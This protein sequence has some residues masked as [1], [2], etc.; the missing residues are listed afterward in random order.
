MTTLA[1]DARINYRPDID[2]LRAIAVLAVVLFHIDA[3]LIQGGFAGVDIFFVI[4]GFLITGNIIKDAGSAQGFSWTEFYRRRALR[5]LPVLFVVLLATLLVGHFILLPEDLSSL[6]YSSLAAVFSAANVY[7]TYFLDTSYF[8]DD[9][10][11][12]P[13]LHLWSLGVEEQF[14]LFWPVILLALLTRFTRR[15]LLSATLLLMLASFV[16]AQV[17]IPKAPMFAYYMLPARAGE[18]MV[19]ALL[20]IWL[21]RGHAVIGNW[22][23]VLLG[24]VGAGLIVASLGWITEDMGFPGVNALPSTLGAALL[25]WAG[26]GRRVGMSRLLSLRPLVLVGLISYSLYLWHWP[27]LAFYRYVYGIVEPLAGVLLFGLMLL[28]SLASYRWVEKPCRRLHW[29]FSQVMLRLVAINAAALS[30]FCGAIL[31]SDG[32]GLYGLDAQYRADI[33]RLSPAPAAYSYPYVCQRPR[34]REAELQSKACIV[35]AEKEP[36]VLLWGDSNAAHYVGMLGAFAEASGFGFRNA[37]HSS[38]PPLLQG[39]AATQKPERLEQCLASIEVVRQH[40]GDYSTVI[41]GAAWATHARKSDSFL[42]NLEATVDE[43]VKQGKQVVIMASVPRF[44]AVNR[45]CS[46]KSLKLPMLVCSESGAEDPGVVPIN[47][48]LSALAAGR[49]NVHF[50]DPRE[51]LCPRGRCSAYL[52]GHLVYFDAGHLSMEGSWVVGRQIVREQGVPDFFSHLGNGVPALGAPSL[53]QALL[54]RGKAVFKVP[55]KR[56]SSLMSNGQ[57]HGNVQ[58]EQR[59]KGMRL[60][61]ASAAAFSAYRYSFAADELQQLQQGI[62]IR[63]QLTMTSCT[64]AMPLLRLRARQGE[65]QSQYDVMLDCA[66]AQLAKRGESGTVEADVNVADGEVKVQ[67]QYVLPG[68]LDALEVSIYPSVGKELGR[69]DAT[70]KGAVVVHDIAWAI[71][72]NKD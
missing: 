37:A 68:A 48:R 41:L 7:F 49:T 58:R 64:D 3:N 56:W 28:L 69:Y 63:L 60:A 31:W 17:L 53:E 29:S 52:D 45:K 62:P 27:V 9:S 8:A 24:L 71:E 50:F 14:Y 59:A 39:T 47:A 11:L 57:W 35:N 55:V 66:S 34:L 32:F 25:I 23:R 54:E 51:Q 44:L 21:S 72:P 40:L 12:Q 20:A 43:L 16:L 30:L 61:D 22:A 10:N 36:A 4:S 13:L 67:A 18:L 33:K 65:R 19:G 38:C 15:W 2:G 6:S 70:S 5:I 26:S 42:K 1:H 46:Q